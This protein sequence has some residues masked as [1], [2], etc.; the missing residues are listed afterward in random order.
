MGMHLYVGRAGTGK[1][2]AVQERI[3]Q[4]LQ[5]DSAATIILLVPDPA[6]YTAERSLAESMK[7]RGFTSV[8]VVGFT[9]LSY[10]VLQSLG[11]TRQ[12]GLSDLGQRLLLR[13]IMK[14]S[15]EELD[16]FKQVSRKPHFA[17]VIQTIISECKAF[18]VSSDDLQAGANKV[19]S[20]VLKRKL[21]E[22]ATIMSRY[23][24]IVQERFGMDSDM[25]YDLVQLLPQS[26][27]MQ[28]TYVFVD[29][30]HWFTPI[31]ERVVHT[32]CQLAKESTI[33]ITL[34]SDAKE[35]HQY[36]KEGTLF[37]RPYEIYENFLTMYPSAEVHRFTD[38]YR[39]ESAILKALQGDFFH[40]PI[41]NYQGQEK[42]TIK[43]AYNRER[44]ADAVCRQM[45]QYMMTGKYRWRDMMVI[46][47][48]TETYGDVLEK[49]MERY[50]IPYFSDRRNP[51]T[52][53]P[54][55][56]LLTSL[57]EVVQT[58]MNHDTMFRLCKTDFMPCTR[59]EIDE[60]ENYCLAHGISGA[61]W[62]DEA[63]Q[64]NEG[65]R[66]TERDTAMTAVKGKLMAIIGPFYEFAKTSHTA[67]EWCRT[68][69]GLIEDLRIPKK[70]YEWTKDAEE[71][72]KMSE[73]ASHEQMY[74]HVICF[75]DELVLLSGD[76]P[77]SL[78]EIYLLL[79]EGIEELT[80][81]LVPPSL[82]HVMITT[83]DRSYT[84]EAEIVFVMGMNEGVFPQRV[85]DEG[86]LNDADRLLL[87][88]EAH[89]QL[90][91]GEMIKNFN[92]N[93]LFYLACTRAKSHLHLSYAGSDE[94]GG[95]LEPSLVIK[96]LE[97][98][99]YG[100]V[101]ALGPLSIPRG[102]EG[103][104]MWRPKQSM[105][106]LASQV[107][108]LT[109]GEHMSPLWQGLY[110]WGLRHDKS[111]MYYATRGIND[112]NEIPTVE[113]SLVEG[114]LLSQ[115]MITGSVTRL[116]R[117]QSCPFSFYAQYALK[118][119]PR[120][121]RQFGAPEIG[122]F[123]HES[124]RRL[125]EQLL[126]NR[127]QWRHIDE[128]MS[129]HLCHEVATS[130]RQDWLYDESDAY[131][132]QLMRRLDET[133]LQ[134]VTRLIDWSKKSKFN[135]KYLEKNFGRGEGAWHYLQ[136]PLDRG[137]A[138]R[139]EGQIDRIDEYR[140]PDGQDYALII[141]YKSGGAGLK[142]QDVYYGLRLQ[143]L[144]YLLALEASLEEAVRPAATVYTY[145]KNPHVSVSDF[146]DYEA[147][148]QLKE[149]VK[150]LQ[151]QGYFLNDDS[152]DALDTSRSSTGKSMYVPIKLK[153]S[154]EPYSSDAWKL[155]TSEEFNLLTEYTKS[156]LA[157][158]GQHIVDGYFPISPYKKS[159][160]TPCSYCQYRALCRF[161][162]S[163]NAYRVLPPLTE[164]AAMEKI[165]EEKG[166]KPY[167]MD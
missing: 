71:S 88:E 52:S 163:R 151:N 139:L 159:D 80:Y 53:H 118:A 130:V 13:L 166:R 4:I 31:Q 120:K 41:R 63:W 100:E 18:E 105:G 7:G 68:L 25:L 26:P 93:F 9:R 48:D 64:Y 10:Q 165:S 74:K 157:H 116:E 96:R 29:G 73:A 129:K 8:R 136:I 154:G 50:D 153:K 61:R 87:K 146:V 65:E 67:E 60:L 110:N 91:A 79:T 86:I 20:L 17:D 81:S 35:I 114:L 144:T 164:S 128:G 47:R 34:P 5:D 140:G 161:E 122:T 123:L 132:D 76:D 124:L 113:S 82:D 89:L 155:K 72:G 121:I 111:H 21:N 3:Q 97:Q 43:S 85:G 158:I 44:E 2:H 98:Y 46:M 138:M 149:E 39:M 150:D 11:K 49:Q 45:W 59:Q 134:T 54:L 83:I 75:L 101:V 125:G 156:M 160:R 37:A 135:T 99:G 167:E 104:Y 42:M 95:G 143:L 90:A 162:G 38:V 117:Y 94:E 14:Q 24:D 109:K 152:L 55:A 141:D 70:L 77:I 147:A 66:G 28:N 58:Y 36:K 51:M 133:L 12:E 107:G 56:E 112:S 33:T 6:T 92:E 40:R 78:S 103:D 126:A 57:F 30:F 16:L 19:S 115:N 119:L 69:Y 108:A 137:Y 106:L 127:Q 131:G 27:L 1:S 148:K 23:D 62:F 102:S 84:G 32:M 142:A 145:V 15:G 22:L